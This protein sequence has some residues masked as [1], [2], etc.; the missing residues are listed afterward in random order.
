MVV[1]SL[2]VL[3]GRSRGGGQ[4]AGTRKALGVGGLPA[5]DLGAAGWVRGTAIT[6]SAESA[7]LPWRSL[8]AEESVGGEEEEGEKARGSP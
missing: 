7:S 1:K 4:G 8:G 6:T 2:E 3:P 5:L